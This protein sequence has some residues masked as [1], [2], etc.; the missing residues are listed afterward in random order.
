MPLH[1]AQC[2]ARFVSENPVS[3]FVIALVPFD[4][5][6]TKFG[7][8]T[9]AEGC[10]SRGSATPHLTGRRPQHLQFV[11]PTYAHTFDLERPNLDNVGG[12]WA[13]S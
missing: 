3:W 12:A 10:V 11:G 7:T 5:K 9:R 6:T 2:I 13:C 4:Y 1:I 8:I